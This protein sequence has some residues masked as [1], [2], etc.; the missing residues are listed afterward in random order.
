M[1]AGGA[2]L[3]LVHLDQP[4]RY[5][6][7]VTFLEYVARPLGRA[8]ALY[9][10]PNNHLFHTF[11]AHLSVS[12][13]GDGPVA[14]R[15]PAFAAGVMVP[16]AVYVAGRSVH[17]RDVGLVAAALAA[18]SPALVLFSANARGYSLVVLAFLALVPPAATLR[19]RSSPVAWLV[20]ATVAALGAWAMPTMLYPAGAAAAWRS[21][22]SA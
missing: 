2:A 16:P 17:G 5:D 6:E 20:F 8:L 13:F 22:N 4:V 9:D 11:L 21:A 12:A 7:A 1:V 15:L 19:R 3:R 18:A 10:L 14:L